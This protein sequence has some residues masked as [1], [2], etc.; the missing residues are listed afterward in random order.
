MPEEDYYS[1][2]IGL[3]VIPFDGLIDG[4][5]ICRLPIVPG[6][7]RGVVLHIKSSN[8]G[9]FPCFADKVIIIECGLTGEHI[10][11]VVVD[12]FLVKLLGLGR[13]ARI[14]EF[15]EAEAEDH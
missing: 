15:I 11:T 7:V 8:N 12:Q 14:Y 9:F 3:G 1:L 13:G 6:I 10:L 2:A 5:I 4:S